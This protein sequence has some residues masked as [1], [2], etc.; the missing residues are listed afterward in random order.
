VIVGSNANGVHFDPIAVPDCAT[1]EIASLNYFSYLPS[2]V[3]HDDI[4]IFSS[5]TQN[6]A[7][8]EGGLENFVQN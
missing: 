4:P 5:Q 6:K 3:H 1:V 2:Y 7:C 8:Y